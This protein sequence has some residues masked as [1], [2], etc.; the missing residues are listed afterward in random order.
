MQN[1]LQRLGGY[2]PQLTPCYLMYNLVSPLHLSTFYASEH[3]ALLSHQFFVSTDTKPAIGNLTYLKYTDMQGETQRVFISEE[4]A[5]KWRQIG[6]SLHFTPDTLDNIESMCCSDVEKCCNRILTLWL[7]GHVQDVS[8]APVTWKT[9]LEAL[10]DARFGQLANNLT[11]LL[12]S[13][14]VQ[15]PPPPSQPTAHTPCTVLTQGTVH[16]CIHTCIECVM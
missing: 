1:T 4:L 9:F 2:A 8:Q 7:E 11:D 5:A 16:S 15:V 3:V 13:H 12:T 6:L 14:D 10:K